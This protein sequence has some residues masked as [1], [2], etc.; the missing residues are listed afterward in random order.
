M[1]RR[2]LERAIQDLLDGTASEGDARELQALLKAEPDAR[3]TYLEYASLH[4]S[5][6]Y[7]ISRS[8]PSRTVAPAA[9]PTRPKRAR[10]VAAALVATGLLLATLLPHPG[11]ATYRVAPQSRLGIGHAA[12]P[13]AATGTLAVGSRFT[14]DQGSAEITLARGGRLVVHGPADLTLDAPD[15]LTLSHGRVWCAAGERPLV[16]HTPGLEVSSRDSTLAVSTDP[17]DDDEVHVFTGRAEVSTAATTAA[18]FTLA[19]GESR[20]LDP[21]GVLHP[22]LIR[23]PSFLHSLPDGLACLEFRFDGMNRGRLA[24][25]G[26]HPDVAAI[27]A[28]VAGSHTSP[29]LVPGVSGKALSLDGQGQHVLTDWPGISGIRPRT[30]TLWVKVDPQAD[31]EH[32]PGLAGWGDPRM[33]NGKWKVLLTQD[34]PN[35]PGYPRI[36]IG[37]HAYDA[38]TPAND[39]RWH[40]LAFSFSGRMGDDGHPQLAI[41]VDGVAQQ[42]TYRSFPQMEGPRDPRT[43]TDAGAEPLTVGGPVDPFPGS[44]HGEIDELRIYDG[45]LPEEAI[46]AEVAKIPANRR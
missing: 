46:R 39:G 24:V 8:S 22:G 27:R 42:L 40:H 15:E 12:I 1:N 31:L 30:I 20:R 7:G 14:L 32:H 23:P 35:G 33:P 34:S 5:L 18:P 41:H 37:G 19:A 38:A 13:A 3:R 26:T 36:S 21:R 16:L 29:R 44:F 28:E 4:Q 25:G 43:R 17:V 45:V 10:F 2:E 9:A 11:T 6:E